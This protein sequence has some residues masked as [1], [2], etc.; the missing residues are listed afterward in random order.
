MK[1]QGQ[2]PGLKRVK[3]ANGRV[4]LYW[5]A[6]DDAKKAG[7]TPTVVRLFGDVDDPIGFQIIAQR[8]MTL[9]A[10]MREWLSGRPGGTN[11]HPHG[12]IS[13]LL[14][15]MLTDE[16][17]PIKARR[18]DTQ[19][20]YDRYGA[21][22][23]RT[24]GARHLSQVTGKDLRRWYREWSEAHGP[25][26]GYACIQTFR[27][28]IGYGCEL[29]EPAAFR[30]HQVMQAME[31]APPPRR[32]Q[33]ATH[34][35]VQALI[36]KAIK[37]GRRS[38]AIAT[39]LQFDLG[40]RQRD[41][42]GEWV[43]AG[44]GRR[45]GI[46][47]GQWRWQWGL[48]WDQIDRDW[49]LR[50]PTSKSNGREVAEHDIKRSPELLALLQSVP[51]ESRIG[52]IVID[53]GAKRPYRASFF[54]RT[55]RK[56]ATEAGWPADVRSMD[57]RAGMVTEALAAGAQ[58]TDVMAAATH[59]QLTTTLGYRRSKFEQTGRVADLRAER[60]KRQNDA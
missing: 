11:A 30:M 19:K 6:H 21:V 44:N 51:L 31:F 53:E 41:V 57:S 15:A 52:P 56:I 29:A 24:V 50:K 1:P 32:T 12:T 42:I 8:C 9:H 4:D 13:W 5:V 2:A 40:L 49:L 17:S 14:T 25:R 18:A 34:A 54:S 27:R 37:A 38:I 58:D 36:P 20:F 60:R 43:S 39:L 3:R 45:E 35:M 48:T 26:S 47:D 22:I 28:A 55:F 16:D 33:Q 46:M 7:F 59:T 10:E 23:I